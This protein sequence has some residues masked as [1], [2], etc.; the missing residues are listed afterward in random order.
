M[1]AP[2]VDNTAAHQPMLFFQEVP[3]PKAAQST[4]TKSG[5]VTRRAVVSRTAKQLR[6]P[7]PWTWNSDGLP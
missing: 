2:Q 3:T 6:Q 1:C 5:Q 4:S 7:F